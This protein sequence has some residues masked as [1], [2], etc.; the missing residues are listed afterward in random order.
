M[1]E[2]YRN[3]H[4]DLIDRCRKGDTQAQFQLYKLYYKAMYN[5]CVRMVKNQQEAEDIMQESFLAVFRHMD[6]YKG[7]VSFGAWIKRIVINRCL[8]HLKKKKIDLCPIEEKLFKLESP[9][10]RDFH[11]SSKGEM[12]EKIKKAMVSYPMDTG[13]FSV[14]TFWRDTIIK[15]LPKLWKLPA[16]P[17]ARNTHGQKRNCWSY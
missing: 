15:R 3:L 11:H 1:N 12:I 6:T 2:I 17:H 9:T 14:F 16:L 5:T 4:Q 7:E 10:E 13:L 8:D